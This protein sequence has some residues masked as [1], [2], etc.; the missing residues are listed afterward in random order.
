VTRVWLVR[1]G[2]ASAHWGE[3]LDPGLSPQ[4]RSDAAAASDLLA[5]GGPMPVVSSPLARTRQTAE[6]IAAAWSVG[7][8]VEPAVTEVPSPTQDLAGRHRWL[9][10]LLGGTWTTQ[11]APLWKW[12][13]ELVAFVCSLAEP[14]V[15][16]THAVAINTVLAEAT[17]DDRV[18]T[19]AVAPGSVTVVDVDP[20]G[21]APMV[22]VA[23]GA[24]DG[25]ARLW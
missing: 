1:H 23:V 24:L 20:G 15:V 16:V 17:G 18:F 10:D 2:A 22:V 6:V 4:G 19:E 14:T 8:V 3:H 9:V 21:E 5:G 25:A 12:R 7:V 13:Q 11:P